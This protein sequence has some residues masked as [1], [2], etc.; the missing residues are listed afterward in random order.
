MPSAST[1]STLI[2]PSLLLSFISPISL[3]YVLFSS[4]TSFSPHDIDVLPRALHPCVL[5]HPPPFLFHIHLIPPVHPH[6]HSSLS[7]TVIFLV[8]VCVCLWEII[9]KLAACFG[10]GAT[11]AFIPCSAAMTQTRPQPVIATNEKMAWHFLVLDC[12]WFKEPMDNY[13]QKQ[14]KWNSQFVHMVYT[15][16]LK[17]C[18]LWMSLFV[19]PVGLCG[20]QSTRQCDKLHISG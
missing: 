2:P 15:T 11:S 14:R 3:S 10:S 7:W 9:W 16:T 8:C 1:F 5:S 6:R 20:L 13:K 4:L 12:M 18:L 17:S 19:N